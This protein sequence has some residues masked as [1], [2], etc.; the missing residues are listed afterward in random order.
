V[1]LGDIAG[2]E[3][4]LTIPLG[5]SMPL[6]PPGSGWTSTLRILETGERATTLRVELLDALG[7]LLGI[8]Y[9]SLNAG[10]LSERAL[11]SLFPGP[12]DGL[13]WQLWIEI[14]SGGP[15]VAWLLSEHADGDA[16]L[17]LGRP[18]L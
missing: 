8:R 3:G 11:A 18:S 14:E 12:V 16:S 17:A 4:S 7:E 10:G 5:A 6:P 15:I 1:G 9:L 2:A 13:G